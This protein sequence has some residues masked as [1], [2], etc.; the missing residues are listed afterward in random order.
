MTVLLGLVCA[1]LLLTIFA[2]CI[3]GALGFLYGLFKK[4]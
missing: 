2:T 4:L 3:S 1:F